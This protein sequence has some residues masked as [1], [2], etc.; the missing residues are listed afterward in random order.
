M[1]LEDL[2]SFKNKLSDININQLYE[3]YTGS[4]PLIPVYNRYYQ[5]LSK[6]NNIKWQL[7]MIRAGYS[8]LLMN[9]G[10][11]APLEQET[12]NALFHIIV[13]RLVYE[14]PDFK[15]I[16]LYVMDVKYLINHQFLT[17][18]QDIK[19]IEPIIKEECLSLENKCINKILDAV[20]IIEPSWINTDK[21]DNL[22]NVSNITGVSIFDILKKEINNINIKELTLEI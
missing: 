12:M 18:L 11:I 16:A 4:D 15:P 20:H 19:K 7:S 14:N 8:S 5:S 2:S 13:K 6:E 3:A 9:S 21:I 10:F 22:N 17:C 1:K